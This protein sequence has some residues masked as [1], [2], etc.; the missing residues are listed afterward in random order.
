M[1]NGQHNSIT[2]AYCPSIPLAANLN[3]RHLCQVFMFCQL[4]LLHLGLFLGLSL[5]NDSLQSWQPLAQGQYVGL[6]AFVP[7][8]KHTLVPNDLLLIGH[9]F[10]A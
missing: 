8:P 6:S 3:C 7:Q 5:R 1:V 10:T 9:H 2:I 4:V